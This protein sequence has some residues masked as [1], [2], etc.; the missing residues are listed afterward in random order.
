MLRFMTGV[1]WQDGVS[2]EEVAKRC[3]LGDI[4]ERIRQRRLQWCEKRGRGE[5]I[6]NNGENAGAKK[7]FEQLVQGGIQKMGL[8]EEQ[9]RDLKSWKE[10]ITA[11]INSKERISLF[12]CYLIL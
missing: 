12:T 9:A 11:A 2:S 4:L 5:G 7:R 1:K 10:I 8:K 6:K 3:S